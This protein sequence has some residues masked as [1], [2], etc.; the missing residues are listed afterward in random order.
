VLPSDSGGSG[1]G[2][3]GVWD[4]A[5]DPR[6]SDH[7]QRRGKRAGETGPRGLASWAAQEAM[8]RAGPRALG[9]KVAKAGCWVGLQRGEESGL[10][11]AC[12]AGGLGSWAKRIG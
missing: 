4:D 9:C 12:S 10:A 7:G 11:V 3:R 5:W 6:V 2:Q 8:W 1:G